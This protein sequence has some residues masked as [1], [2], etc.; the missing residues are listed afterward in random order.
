MRDDDRRLVDYE[1][2]FAVAVDGRGPAVAER[3]VFVTAL[4]DER[5]HF[6][7]ERANRLVEAIPVIGCGR[8]FAICMEVLLEAHL[9]H[10]GIFGQPIVKLRACVHVGPYAHGSVHPERRVDLGPGLRLGGFDHFID[11]A[12]REASVPQGASEACRIVSSLEAMLPLPRNEKRA[13]T[14]VHAVCVP[15]GVA[16]LDV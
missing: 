3:S 11:E 13:G 2:S 5:Q 16:E 9:R 14:D 6:E 8:D 10:A 7:K 12:F 15:S 4:S 1:R